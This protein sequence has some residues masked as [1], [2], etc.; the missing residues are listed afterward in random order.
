[1]L[2][3]LSCTGPVKVVCLQEACVPGHMFVHGSAAR[4]AVLLSLQHLFG[5]QVQMAL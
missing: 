3:L 2:P 1:M 5:C 4:L